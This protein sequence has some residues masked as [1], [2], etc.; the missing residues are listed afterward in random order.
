MQDKIRSRIDSLRESTKAW[1]NSVRTRWSKLSRRDQVLTAGAGV[2]LVL[3]A[4]VGL[5]IAALG[6]A[7]RC[8]EPVCVEVIGPTGERVH[9]MTPIQIRVVGDID[10][11]LAVQALQIS[12]EPKG[13]KK[14]EGDILAFRPEWPGFARGVKYQVA[15]ALP[16]SVLPEGQQ[17]R[18]FSF[19]FTTDGKL[20]ISAVFPPD[21]AAEVALDASIMLQFSRSVAP[22]TVV[23]ERRPEE[24]I[25]FDP[26]VEGKGKWLNTSLYTFTPTAPGWTPAIRYAATAKAGLTNDLGGRLDADYRFSFTTL[27]PD[28][29]AVNPADNSKFVAPQ[30]DITVQFNQP[31]DHASA[32]ASFSLAPGGGSPVP[33]G[34]LWPDD[35]TLVFRPAQALPLET[36]FEAVVKPG[37]IALGAA[38]TMTAEKRWTFTTVGVPRIVSTD[39]ANGGHSPGGGVVITFS[40]P[41]DQ[42]SVESHVTVI[43]APLDTPY[44]SWNPDGLTLYV[45]F[46]TEPSSWHAPAAASAR[47]TLPSPFPWCWR[48]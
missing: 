29:A 46:P 14:F 13:T 43:P 45:S 33:G 38:A 28:V 31:V 5:T 26:P 20:E 21:A 30:P 25:A 40:N 44:F 39:P 22:L 6:G 18:D 41:M 32:E 3:V 9:P 1:L 4:T 35:R 27:S 15:L 42:E 8:D 37:T 17:A 23:S 10:R 47:S 34:F 19:N 16:S 11:E 7:S 48:T 2:L 12:N 24:V 36:A